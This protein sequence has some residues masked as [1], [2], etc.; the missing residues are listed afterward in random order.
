MIGSNRKCSGNHPL[1]AKEKQ[2]TVSDF[3]LGGRP[4]FNFESL[5]QGGP[6]M[7]YFATQNSYLKSKRTLS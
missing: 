4:V 1:Y 7:G 6:M 5:G 3:L 2:E